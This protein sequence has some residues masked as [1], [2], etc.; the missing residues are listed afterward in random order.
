MNV[1]NA[2]NHLI[3]KKKANIDVN[4]LILLYVSNAEIRYI[5]QNL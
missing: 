2:I 5:I 3:S 4:I 1:K